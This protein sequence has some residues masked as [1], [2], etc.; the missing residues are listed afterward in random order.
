MKSEFKK[1]EAF[2]LSEMIVALAITTIVV[3]MSYA[4]LSLVQKQ[5]YGIEENYEKNTKLHLLKQSLWYDFNTGDRVFYN[6]EKRELSI[7]NEL[8]TTRYIIEENIIIK[9]KD[10][11]ALGWEYQKFYFQN[12]EQIH[13]EIDAIDFRTASEFG[14][15]QLFVYKNNSASTYMNN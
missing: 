8:R 13:G 14:N 7:E 11:F 4:V 6:S 12:K 1:I 10:T 3:G 9:E 15:Q 2:T 5:M